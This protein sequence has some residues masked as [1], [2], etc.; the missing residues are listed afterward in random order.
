MLDQA[1][2]VRN[3]VK[4]IASPS[5]SSIERIVCTTL[6]YKRVIIRRSCVCERSSFDG[7]RAGVAESQEIH[8]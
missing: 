4:G 5:S 1:R 3:S 2:T 8:G 6:L 7:D